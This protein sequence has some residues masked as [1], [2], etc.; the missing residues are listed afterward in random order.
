[1]A[2]MVLLFL[3]GFQVAFLWLHDWVKLAPLND[4]AAVRRENPAG[5]LMRTTIIQSLPFTVGLVYSVIDFQSGFPG[6][7]WNWLWI[8]YGILFVG[9]LRAW[10]VPYLFRPEPG[11]AARYRVMF[12]GTWAFL[13]ERHGMVPN[14]LHCLLHACT[15]ATLIVLGFLLR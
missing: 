10:W 2:G 7:L 13:P 15:L 4:V 8:S 1:M 14:T 3:Q 9:E 12:G 6:W 5:A 11:R